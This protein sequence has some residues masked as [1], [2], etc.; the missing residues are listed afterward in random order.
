[1]SDSK[2]LEYTSNK[3]DI[4]SKKI[5]IQDITRHPIKYK[6]EDDRYPKNERKESLDKKMEEILL[7]KRVSMPGNDKF[8]EDLDGVFDSPLANKKYPIWAWIVAVIALINSG[9][10][11]P[12]LLMVNANIVVKA[13][14]RQMMTAFLLIPLA[15]YEYKKGTSN[16]YQRSVLFDFKVLRKMLLASLFHA[17]WT[18]TFAY[19]INYTCMTHVYIL[20]NMDIFI[21][22]FLKLIRGEKTSNLEKVGL[23]ITIIGIITLYL[24]NDFEGKVP[25]FASL[26]LFSKLFK[27]N[28]IAFIGSIATSL[29]LWTCYR[30][31]E[32][33]PSWLGITLINFLSSILQLI[34]CLI[35]ESSTFDTSTENGIFGLFTFKW[36]FIHIGIAFITGIGC[37]CLLIVISR[38][39]IPLHYHFILNLEPISGALVAYFF[40]LQMLPGLWTWISLC[41]IIV[42]LTIILVGKNQMEAQDFELDD[43]YLTMNT[44]YDRESFLPKRNSLHLLGRESNIEFKL[45]NS[46][47]NQNKF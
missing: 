2:T 35:F 45:Y 23:F 46:K 5:S 4:F 37:F 38:I 29:Y 19:S 8:L 40:G 11:G 31:T 13:G 7:Q 22:C 24:D 25:D 12:F 15:L 30:I 14:W 27:G 39:F 16:L 28:T 6:N 3:D 47:R 44:V 34:F 41:V 18:I 32:E 43:A 9:F 17:I 20:N 36:F 21:N 42:A 26:S 10:I 1:M 33:Y